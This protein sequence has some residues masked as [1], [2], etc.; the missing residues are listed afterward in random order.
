LPNVAPPVSAGTSRPRGLITLATNRIPTFF[1]FIAP[2]HEQGR[3]RIFTSL[4]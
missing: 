1:Q 4:V 2:P 3:A